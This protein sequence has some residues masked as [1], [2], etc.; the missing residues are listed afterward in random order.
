[1]PFAVTWMIILSE[2]TQKK[3]DIYHIYMESKKKNDT[4]YLQKETD[5][6]IW[7]TYLCL[8]MGRGWVVEGWIGSLGLAEANHYIENG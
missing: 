7:R 8:P 5:S 4:N 3:K 6:Q 1:M 2:I